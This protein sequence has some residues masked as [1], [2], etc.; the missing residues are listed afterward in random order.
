[1]EPSYIVNFERKLAIRKYIFFG[2]LLVLLFGIP[3]WFYIDASLE[4]ASFGDNLDVDTYNART[5]DAMLF[6]FIM[7]FLMSVFVVPTLLYINRYFNRYQT[8]LN[9]L[10]P[11]EIETLKTIN[12]A[13]YAR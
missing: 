12:D 7:L 4:T 2:F 13:L 1:M 5:N 9:Q 8:V 10:K 6:T 3:L 11:K